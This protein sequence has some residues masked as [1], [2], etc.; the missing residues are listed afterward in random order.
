MKLS[1]YTRSMQFCSQDDKRAALLLPY[2]HDGYIYFTDGVAAVRMRTEFPHFAPDPYLRPWEFD[3]DVFNRDVV[4]VPFASS[5]YACGRSAWQIRK[6]AALKMAQLPMVMCMDD[7]VVTD[8]TLCPILP[9]TFKNGLGQGFTA[10][11]R[12]RECHE[13]VQ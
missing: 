2:I 3:W 13:P 5:S 8:A 9:F 1:M 4:P 10:L 12:R 6:E 11:E 7:A